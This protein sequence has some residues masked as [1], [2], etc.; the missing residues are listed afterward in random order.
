MSMNEIQALTHTDPALVVR[1]P[2]QLPHLALP[3]LSSTT[4]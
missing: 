4:C 2:E 3:Q 1:G